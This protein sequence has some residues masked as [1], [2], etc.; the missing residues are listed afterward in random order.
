VSLFYCGNFAVTF[1]RIYSLTLT[2]LAEL[3][4]RPIWKDS[5]T[6]GNAWASI[7]SQVARAVEQWTAGDMDGFKSTMTTLRGMRHNTG[8][9]ADKLATLQASMTR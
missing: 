4:E 6:G 7:A 2:D 5:A 9:V 3:F 1:A 8:N